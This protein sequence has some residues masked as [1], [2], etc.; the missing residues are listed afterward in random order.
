MKTVQRKIRPITI[1]CGVPGCATKPIDAAL[2]EKEG[3]GGE[4]IA[5]RGWTFPSPVHGSGD[6]FVGTCPAHVA[7]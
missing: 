6:V 3:G 2:D 5:P 1:R 7:K 4:V